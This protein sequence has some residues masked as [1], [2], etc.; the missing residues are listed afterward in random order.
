MRTPTLLLLV[1]F[2]AAFDSPLDGVHRGASADPRGVLRE[3][4]RAQADYHAAHG[5]Y[6]ASLRA[7]GVRRPDDVQLR[8]AA[9]GAGGWSAVATAPEEECAVFH[10]SAPAPRGYARSAGRIAC[11]A[12]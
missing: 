6:T 11:R 9:Q 12:R 4:Q 8:I 5:R 2:S 1:A 7:L 3:V 10:G